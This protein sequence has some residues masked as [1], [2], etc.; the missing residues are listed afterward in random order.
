MY[1]LRFWQRE[2]GLSEKERKERKKYNKKGE[3]KFKFLQA[4]IV[5]FY[6]IAFALTVIILV[7]TVSMILVNA[8]KLDIEDSG[9][10]SENQQ[11]MAGT[12]LFLA[13]RTY[14]PNTHQAEFLFQVTREPLYQKQPIEL[15]VTEKKTK[16]EL[17]SEWLEL[18]EEY[19]LVVVSDIPDNW[20]ELVF[21]MGE[22]ELY[23]DE[24]AE[25]KTDYLLTERSQDI[26]QK[27]EFMQITFA[28]SQDKTR[29]TS[30]KP[31]QSEEDYLRY[32]ATRQMTSAD[33]YMYHYRQEIKKMKQDIAHMD[34]QIKE[35][36]EDQKYQT[37]KQQEQ[38]NQ[39]IT[40]IQHEQ[41]RLQEKVSDTKLGIQQLER[42]KEKLQNWLTDHPAE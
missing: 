11:K 30:G 32:Y 37:E 41:D 13:D 10:G 6:Y 34:T 9:S 26:I 36:K 18:N 25:V 2:D 39:D 5:R 1:K 8:G 17:P 20:K 22:H 42:R 33:D 38:S 4:K 16:K 24:R 23:V 27:G 12:T 40:S 21:D 29:Q 35:L 7:S 31:N 28:F 15:L 19:M 14:H 3:R